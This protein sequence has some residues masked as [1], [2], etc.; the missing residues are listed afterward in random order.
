MRI[1][2]VTLLLDQ[3]RADAPATG[4]AIDLAAK[5]SAH[6]SGV[7]LAVDPVVPGFVFA[8]M[9]V[10]VFES[11]REA[12]VGS[13]RAA[14]ERF[15]A[16][17]ARAGVSREGRFGE[18]L[19]GG[20]PEVFL[21]SA[22]TTDVVVIGQADPDRPEPMREQLIETAL[23]DGGALVLLVPYIATPAFSTKNVMIAWDG[24]ATAAR[25]IRLSLPILALAEKLTVVMVGAPKTAGMP[26][27]DVAT[28]LARHGL[29][30][31]VEQVPAAATGVADALLNHVSDRGFD[32]V[33]MG[34][35][36]HSR[37]REFILGG[38][39]RDMLRSMTVP[40]LM[41]H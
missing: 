3:A 5:L 17:A 14:A 39:T 21:Q 33:V 32:L 6:L 22:R 1:K 31:E 7:A 30:V 19:M 27:A 9:P 36:G 2:D 25:A 8:P 29:K 28:W 12:A 34:G 23:F 15:E 35:Y 41:A 4:L 40:V 16:E 11:A 10:E 24:S 20:L 18:V 13:A 26:G 38:A 37:M